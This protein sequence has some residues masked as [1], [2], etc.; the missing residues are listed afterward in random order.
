MPSSTKNLWRMRPTEATVLH[1]SA[2]RHFYPP[3]QT[4]QCNQ[5][6]FIHLVLY[7]R[8]IKYYQVSI[9]IEWLSLYFD[10]K[11]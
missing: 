1:W 8:F 3:T 2:T 9:N 5:Q 6:T 7:L 4:E 11:P 10:P